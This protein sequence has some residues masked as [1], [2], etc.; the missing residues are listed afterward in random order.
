M[1]GGNIFAGAGLSA[2]DGAID[3]GAAQ[4]APLA[5]ATYG[6]QGAGAAG[7][8]SPRRGQ[9]AGFWLAVGGVVVL[10]CIRQSLPR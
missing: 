8:L 3:G 9:G 5:A 6:P 4:S 2:D 10:V 1:I 7:P